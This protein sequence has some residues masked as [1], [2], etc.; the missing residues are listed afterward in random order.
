MTKTLKNILALINVVLAILIHGF[1][2]FK[3]FE[4]HPN[5]KGW[6]EL[7]F[8]ISS[9]I[10]II[11]GF[12]ISTT[13]QPLNKRLRYLILSPFILIGAVPIMVQN[14]YTIIF[15]IIV[16]ILASILSLFIILKAK[17]RNLLVL[18]GILI[19]INLFLL[20][21]VINI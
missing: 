17:D 19:P 3:F 14:P 8:I 6:F 7:L 13:L 4:S 5:S 20:W 10:F 15:V 9:G 16:L 2:Y 12:I 18:N 1:S 11:N 21:I